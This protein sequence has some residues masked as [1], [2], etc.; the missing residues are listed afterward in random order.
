MAFE[1]TKALMGRPHNAG[2]DGAAA[3]SEAVRTV[4]ALTA[5]LD[6]EFK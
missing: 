1:L 5:E 4:D 3:A 6:K 2:A